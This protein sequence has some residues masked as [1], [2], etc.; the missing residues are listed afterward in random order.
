VPCDGP[1]QA[2]F[3]AGSQQTSCACTAQQ[4]EVPRA[5][6]LRLCSLAAAELSDTVIF[7]VVIVVSSMRRIRRRYF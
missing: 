3:S 2:D 5:E 1:Q 4:P 6:S 7:V